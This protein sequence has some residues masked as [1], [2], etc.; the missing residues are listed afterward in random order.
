MTLT[1]ESASIAGTVSVI[2]LTG[3]SPG[4]TIGALVIFLI[5]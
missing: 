5:D 1:L 2:V 4:S 3:G